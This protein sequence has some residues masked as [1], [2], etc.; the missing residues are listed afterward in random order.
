M[1]D[2]TER[3][4]RTERGLRLRFLPEGSGSGYRGTARKS[5]NRV[6]SEIQKVQKNRGWTAKEGRGRRAVVCS[7][8]RKRES[9]ESWRE[10]EKEK[11]DESPRRKRIRHWWYRTGNPSVANQ[12][13]KRSVKGARLREE[14]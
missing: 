7:R 5:R 11:S 2:R 10:K 9:G 3:H 4:G 12:G 8:E 1:G 6:P 13:R 14:S